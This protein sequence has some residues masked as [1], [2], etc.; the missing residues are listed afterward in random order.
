MTV[1]SWM[2]NFVG[3]CEKSTAQDLRAMLRIIAV[4]M[5]QRHLPLAVGLLRAVEDLPPDAV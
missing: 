1:S 3:F 2:P 4:E 5:T